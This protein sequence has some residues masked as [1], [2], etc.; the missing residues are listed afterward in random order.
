MS[1]KDR[2]NYWQTILEEQRRSGLSV[3]D[4][5]VK[6]QVISPPLGP[7]YF[8]TFAIRGVNISLG[9]NWSQFLPIGL[10]SFYDNVMRMVRDTVKG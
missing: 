1:R 4:Q 5:G 7:R 3:K 10:T 9:I 8:P 6:D 2:I